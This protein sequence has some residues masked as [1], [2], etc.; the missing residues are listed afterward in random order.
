MDLDKSAILAM[1]D[2]EIVPVQVPEWENGTV[3]LKGMSGTDRDRVEMEASRIVKGSAGNFRAL[4]VAK[5]LCNSA[6]VRM[7]SD[8]EVP[9]LGEKSGKVLDR[10]F[11]TARKLSGMTP[12]DVETLEKN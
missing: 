7:F 4:V 10:L 3:Y 6:G 12:E 1:S 8:S 2:L 11:D 9:A 5:C